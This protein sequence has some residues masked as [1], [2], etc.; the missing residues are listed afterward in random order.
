MRPQHHLNSCKCVASI[1]AYMSS[2]I[3]EG[4]RLG[5]RTFQKTR[6]TDL[7]INVHADAHL[8]L[9]Q[10]WP[11][12]PVA[13]LPTPGGLGRRRLCGFVLAAALPQRHLV[14]L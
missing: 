11:P 14:L 12:A 4:M 3:S 13:A 7:R 9:C 2:L 8:E 5:L 1:K 6:K 10:L